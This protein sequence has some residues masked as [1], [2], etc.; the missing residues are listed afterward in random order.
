MA[1]AVVAYVAD[2]PDL[3]AFVGEV[4][5]VVGAVLALYTVFLAVLA[6]AYAGTAVA[7]ARTD[8]RTGRAALLLAHPVARVR[9]VGAHVLLGAVASTVMMLLAGL[10][11]GVG[12]ALVL[13]DPAQVGSLLGAAAVTV[14]GVLV[15]L[16][17]ATLVDGWAPRAGGVVWAYVAYVG[18]VGLLGGLLPA[19]TDALSPFAHLPAL[20]AERFALAPVLVVTGTAAVLVAVGLAGARRRDVDG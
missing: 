10:V 16:G 14:P 20:P 19:G 2:Q 5:D 12:S 6:A 7:A 11:M 15:V 3:T 4:D 1:D 8:E 18:L 13:D 9:R 17:L